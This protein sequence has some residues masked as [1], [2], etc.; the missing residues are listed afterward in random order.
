MILADTTDA[1]AYERA[2]SPRLQ[3]IIQSNMR[4]SQRSKDRKIT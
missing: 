3:Q 2:R 1:V 4:S